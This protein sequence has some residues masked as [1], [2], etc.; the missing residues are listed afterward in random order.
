MILAAVAAIPLCSPTPT[1][2]ARFAYTTLA[3]FTRSHN[4]LLSATNYTALVFASLF[5]CLF[6]FSTY[7][8]LEFFHL[9]FTTNK[10][11]VHSLREFIRQAHRVKGLSTF[12]LVLIDIPSYTL[13]RITVKKRDCEQRTRELE[14]SS[15]TFLV[16]SVTGLLGP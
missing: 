4:S 16:L 11:E 7:F 2:L 1:A 9:I 3:R 8:I 6:V 12:L 14:H 15:L 5:S 13:V 10:L